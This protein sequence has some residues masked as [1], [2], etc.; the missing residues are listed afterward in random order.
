MEDATLQSIATLIYALSDK[1]EALAKPQHIKHCSE[2]LNELGAALAK[3]QSAMQVAG[4]NA[5][6]GHFK[7][8]YADL[9][10]VVR[11]SRPC[12]ASNG[13]SVMQVMNEN[14]Y[15]FVLITRLQHVSGQFIESSVRIKPQGNSRN[16]IQALA[17]A[18]TY[19]RRYCYA[20]LVG[21]VASDEDD[22]AESVVAETREAF[23]KGTALNT[24]YNAKE[25]TTITITRE[26][27]EEL[28]YELAEYDDIAD[29]VLT[30]LRIRNLADM[31]KSKYMISLQRIREIK[32]ARAG[33]KKE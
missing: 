10:E 17:S 19:M 18:I 25:N 32:A 30:A 23:A 29:T 33:I 15:G 22:D 12:L 1:I 7:K 2:N 5:E 3:A 24:K 8:G 20:S 4:L 31:P 26:Q 9:A 13:L 14:D 11:V 6:N 27:L 16:D 21:V 28:E